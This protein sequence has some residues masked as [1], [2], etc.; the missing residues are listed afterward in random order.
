MLWIEILISLFNVGAIWLT[1]HKRI[2][3]G[4]LIG[5]VAQVGWAIMFLYTKQ[6]GIIPMEIILLSIYTK[7]L[8]KAVKGKYGNQS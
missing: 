2:L 5:A 6:Y 8:Y 1:T 4:C 3:W 7:H